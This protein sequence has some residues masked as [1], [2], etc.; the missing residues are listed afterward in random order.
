MSLQDY[1]TKIKLATELRD[2]AD[3]LYQRDHDYRS[4]VDVLLPAFMT[5][6]EK[7]KVSLSSQSPEHVSPLCLLGLLALE[8]T[9]A[10]VET[11]SP[12]S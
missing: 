2:N 3:A 4:F 9:S 1:S 11:S 7:G 6:L 10:S 8:L 5:I 12:P